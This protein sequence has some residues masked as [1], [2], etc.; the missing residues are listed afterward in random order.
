M[1]GAPVINFGCAG[2][3][4]IRQ[5]KIATLHL[6]RSDEPFKQE[7]RPARLLCYPDSERICAYN[8]R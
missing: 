2:I 4:E 1:I 5:S 3:L 8:R 7:S 6:V